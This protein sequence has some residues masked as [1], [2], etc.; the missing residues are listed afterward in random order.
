M[1]IRLHLVPA[2]GHKN[3]DAIGNDDIQRLKH[4]LTP[5]AAKTVN[6]I[7]TVAKRVSAVAK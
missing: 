4:W 3:L 1:I 6:N 7:L 5:K 2:V